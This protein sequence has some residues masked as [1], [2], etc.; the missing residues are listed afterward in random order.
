MNNENLRVF[1]IYAE[2]NCDSNC[3]AIIGIPRSTLWQKIDALEKELNIQ[4]VNRKRH[5]HS[6][7]AAGNVLFKRGRS[8]LEDYE[9]LYQDL[10]N[11]EHLQGEIKLSFTQAMATGWVLPGL[12]EFVKNHKDIKLN[13][14]VSDNLQ[15]DTESSSDILLRPLPEGSPYIKHWYVEYHHALYASKEYLAEHG[16]PKVPEDLK[17]HIVL[18]YGNYPFTHFED[19]NW[20]V[21][22]M[23]RIPRL[24]P[25]LQIN[26]TPGL[27]QLATL[28]VGIVSCPAESIALYNKDLVRIFPNI[29]GPTVRT[30]FATNPNLYKSTESKI[31]IIK[32]FIEKHLKKHVPIVYLRT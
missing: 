12:K 31:V 2:N 22:G 7:T 6:L 11:G 18:G 30:Y 26:S 3:H 16:T 17:N 27:F 15:K 8:V 23:N 5:N 1:L 13:I 4:L 10:H 32:K 20:H 29:A 28:G 19:V 9:N 14:V 24:S 21:N 25:T